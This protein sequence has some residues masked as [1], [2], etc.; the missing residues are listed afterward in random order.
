MKSWL[1]I[2]DDEP[3]SAK[4]WRNSCG[5]IARA[6]YRPLVFRGGL[7][8]PIVRGGGV[9]RGAGMEVKWWLENIPR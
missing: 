9:V 1:L 6:R 2:T 7:R 3:D 5:A 4:W 8:T